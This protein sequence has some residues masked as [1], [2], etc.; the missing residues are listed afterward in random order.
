M[1]VLRVHLI[2]HHRGHQW[3]VVLFLCGPQVE[4]GRR[5]SSVQR[6]SPVLPHVIH[7]SSF[8]R[9]KST[10]GFAFT[11][12]SYVCTSECV[13]VYVCLYQ[14]V[15]VSVCVYFRAC[16]RVCAYLCTCIC[17]CMCVCTCVC[18]IPDVAVEDLSEGV[19]E[20]DHKRH[21]AE[22]QDSGQGGNALQH[23]VDPH[24]RYL[25]HPTRP[26]WAETQ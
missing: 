22:E 3:P 2:R 12:I 5:T 24:P 11:F 18:L 1:L 17:E 10:C 15:P 21:H 20:A 9:D 19:Q 7:L 16:T 25:V 14:C 26:E 6:G 13:P 8:L 23:R 4:A